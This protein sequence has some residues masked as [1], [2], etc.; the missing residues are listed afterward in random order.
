MNST[1]AN[2]FPIGTFF[3]TLPSMDDVDCVPV[4]EPSHAGLLLLALPFLIR[5]R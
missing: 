5:R 4:P 1:A 3:S 2:P